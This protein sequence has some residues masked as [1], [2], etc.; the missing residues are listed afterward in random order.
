MTK[1]T[2]FIIGIAS[3][4][5]IMAICVFIMKIGNNANIAN[6]PETLPTLTSQPVTVTIG[7]DANITAEGNVQINQAE[8]E[9]KSNV[10]ENVPI[11]PKPTPPAKKPKAPGA[12]IDHGAPPAY[13]PKDTVKE[14]QKSPPG[15][16][17]P[18]IGNKVYVEGFG[19]IESSGENH[20][21][22]ADSNGDIN[23]MV[24]T[25]D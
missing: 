19:Y 8:T 16:N 2:K 14:T 4:L 24:G 21:A 1:K 12:Y 7:E 11:P 13:D 3:A 23:K 10:Q 17:N 22:V 6:V 18:N 9:T 5:V 25:M 20:G 15:N